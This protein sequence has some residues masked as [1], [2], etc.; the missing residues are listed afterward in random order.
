MRDYDT[1]KASLDFID[2]SKH[3]DFEVLY[4]DA[5]SAEPRESI[6]RYKTLISAVLSELGM[7]ATFPT[8]D[9]MDPLIEKSLKRAIMGTITALLDTPVIS[10]NNTINNDPN[11]ISTA[12]IKT[13][14]FS[15]DS[16]DFSRV[17]LGDDT[18]GLVLLTGGVSGINSDEYSGSLDTMTI[19]ANNILITVSMYN[20]IVQHEFGHIDHADSARSIS[21]ASYIFKYCL[22][23]AI[24]RTNPAGFTYGV[25]MQA[26]MSN[27]YSQFGSA[28]SYLNPDKDVVTISPYG[29]T[30]ATEDLAEIGGSIYTPSHNLFILE[31]DTTVLHEKMSLSIAQ[32]MEEH[33]EL[34]DY[35]LAL[36]RLQHIKEVASKLLNRD[37]AAIETV[38]QV[39]QTLRHYGRNMGVG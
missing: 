2:I 19:R 38:Q 37:A 10:I 15:A 7:E 18:A 24:Q 21:P 22:T 12:G 17:G 6:D 25:D 4:R 8:S 26:S 31:G 5:N 32:M 35:Y 27:E 28:T 13:I 20:D 9:Q 16:N 14:K 30:E 23:N 33:P 36:L 34:F 29:S 39:D 11:D 1:A 3:P